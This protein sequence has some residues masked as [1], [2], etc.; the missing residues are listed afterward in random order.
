MRKLGLL[1]GLAVLAIVVN[2]A[3]DNT[4]FVLSFWGPRAASLDSAADRSWADTSIYFLL[5]GLS[6]LGWFTVPAFLFA[7]GFYVAYA[8]RGRAANLKPRILGGWIRNLLSPYL[9]WILASIALYLVVTALGPGGTPKALQGL[10]G[11]IEGRALGEYYYVPLLVGLLV[12]SPLLVWAACKSP[13][14]LLGASALVMLAFTVQQVPNYG[15]AKILQTLDFLGL[16]TG[17]T[18]CSWKL[19]FDLGLLFFFVM[20]LVAGNRY[21]AFQRHLTA[22]RW[23]L[24]ILAVALLPLSMVE[25][26]V[27]FRSEETRWLPMSWSLAPFLYS[28]AVIMAIFAW[29]WRRGRLE[30]VLDQLGAQSYGIYLM[31]FVAIE[32]TLKLVYHAARPLLAQPLLLLPLFL[33]AA[34]GVPLLTIVVVSKS[35]LRRHYRLVLG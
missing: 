9:T 30:R 23:P 1:R 6:Q 31:Q 21:E 13:L 34:L 26:D 32:Y 16:W 15:A 11:Y 3:A 4:M 29:K 17:L 12:A 22:W 5:L 2:H 19:S 20:G 18:S 24:T 14:A 10:G 25:A 7:S 8:S 35:P 33:A 27:A 28:I